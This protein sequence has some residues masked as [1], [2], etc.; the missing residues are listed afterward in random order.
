M[1]NRMNTAIFVLCSD[2]NGLDE[3]VTAHSVTG[4]KP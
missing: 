4:G 3:A 2:L 1:E